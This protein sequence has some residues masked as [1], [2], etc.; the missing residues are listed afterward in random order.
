MARLHNASTFVFTPDGSKKL[1][2]EL[3][4]IFN[5]IKNVLI[6]DYKDEGG[7]HGFTIRLD[8]NLTKEK[9]AEAGEYL[10]VVNDTMRIVDA[11]EEAKQTEDEK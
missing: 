5:V 1:N 11:I 9:I 7:G 3:E 2:V 6:E 8:L 4:E 10:K